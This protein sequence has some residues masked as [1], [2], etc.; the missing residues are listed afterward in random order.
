MKKLYKKYEE[1]INY[2]IV[3]VLTTLITLITYFVIINLVFP[4]KTNIEIQ[5][6]N[7]I[8]WIIAVTFAY[9]TNRKF[10]F[11]SK[12]KGKEKTKEAL[13]FFSSRIAS[14]LMDMF[15]MFM[16]Y[17]VMHIDDTICKLIDQIVIIIMN[18]VLA[19]LVVFK[20]S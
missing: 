11:K 5:I 19:K 18:Y 10:V 13:N 14:L 16:L 2:L 1:V 9:I 3:G 6:A 4:S 12:T 20:K 17:S 15:L 7:V 8:S